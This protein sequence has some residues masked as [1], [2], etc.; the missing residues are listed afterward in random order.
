MANA[1]IRAK[2]IH[3]TIRNN[4]TTN[5]FDLSIHIME[6]LPQ[7]VG[8]NGKVQGVSLPSNYVLALSELRNGTQLGA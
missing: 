5:I 8:D 6:F 7:F 3:C 2:F 4:I 1:T